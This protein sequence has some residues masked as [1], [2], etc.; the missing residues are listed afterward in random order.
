MLPDLL[1]QACNPSHSGGRGKKF[2]YVLL[3]SE[4]KA[5]ET[6]RLRLKIKTSETG[7]GCSSV[8]ECLP[9]RALGS[10]PWVGVGDRGDRGASGLGVG[11]KGASCLRCV[12]IQLPH[13]IKVHAPW[14]PSDLKVFSLFLL[15]GSSWFLC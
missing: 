9:Y 2:E 7:L 15:W 1:A 6:Q 5:Q 4:F 13:L 3:Y 12:L 14:L 11:R 8:V 10:T